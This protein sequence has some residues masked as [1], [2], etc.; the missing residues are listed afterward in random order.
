MNSNYDLKSTTYAYK[1]YSFA[2]N[3]VVRAHFQNAIGTVPITIGFKKFK[4]VEEALNYLA[5]REDVKK[6]LAEM[7][8]NINN[9]AAYDINPTTYPHNTLIDNVFNQARQK[10]WAKINQSDHEGY[11]AVQKLKAE[12][13]GH[14]TRTRTNRNEILELAN[15]SKPAELFPK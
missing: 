10:A 9:P 15:P 2:E 14:T 11:S 5:K 6:S 3:A 4:N 13:D 8:G 1:G 12:K 7:K